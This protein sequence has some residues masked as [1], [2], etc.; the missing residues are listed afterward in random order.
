MSK[1]DQDERE[2]LIQI[3]S[4]E[5]E[6]I[7]NSFSALLDNVCFSLKT[8]GVSTLEL[9]RRILELPA[10]ISPNELKPLMSDEA[11]RLMNSRTIEE[12][13]LVLQPHMSF[14]NFD[15]L[16]HIINGRQTGS[17]E[18]RQQFKEYCDQFERYCRHRIVEIPSGA[19][20]Q[21]ST[22]LKECKRKA[23]VVHASAEKPL[24]ELS[25]GDAEKVKRR[26]A[27]LLGLRSS[28]LYLHRIEEGSL[29]LVFSIPNFVAQKLFPLSPSLTN[30][31]MKN[32]CLLFY[33][34]DKQGIYYI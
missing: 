20:D 12:S 29:I 1:L 31:L 28:T 5:T 4:L 8:R 14:F 32:G 19:I 24:A 6:K 16:K 23:F 9:A 2:D 34:D 7:I 3:L 33:P 13:L 26:I 25:L 30:T 22:D 11:E 17:D 21:S 10:Y 15:I 27:N 18:D